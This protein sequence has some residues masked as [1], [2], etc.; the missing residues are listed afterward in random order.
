MERIGITTTVPLEILLAAGYTPV[1]LNN[2]FVTDK[3]PGRLVAMAER[4]GFPLS[5][6][7]WIKGLFGTCLEYGIKRVLGVTAGDCSNTLMLLDV[8]KLYD[9]QVLPFAFPPE[10]QV[11]AVRD[12]LKDLAKLLGTDLAAA[13][14]IR[15]ALAAPRQLAHR[16][17]ELTWKEDRASGWENHLWLVS[18][19]DFNGDAE[20]YTREVQSLVEDCQRREPYPSDQVRLAYLGVPPIYGYDLYHFLERHGAR[21][22]LNEI[23]RQ[24][25][26]PRP[27]SCLADQYANY[28]YPYSTYHRLEDITAEITRRRVDGV[29]HYVQAF[30]HEEIGDIIVRKFIPLPVLTLQGDS[31]YTLSAQLCTRLEA[32]LDVIRR[33]K[34][35]SVPPTE[36]PISSFAPPK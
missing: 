31:E 27:G 9:V 28:T 10:P 12:A 6:C 17:D 34:R 33:Q 22:V 24:F 25:A 16:L 1:D 14:R 5:C 30:C 15:A 8:L 2:I 35:S 29:I 7:T 4:A 11:E 19:S 18:A 32:F 21:V 23:Q 20:K 3:D 26:M 36:R 13:E